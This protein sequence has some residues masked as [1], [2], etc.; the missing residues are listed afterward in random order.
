MALLKSIPEKLE[1]N[2]AEGPSLSLIAPSAPPLLLSHQATSVP[3]KVYYRQGS[4]LVVLGWA[5]LFSS[6][7]QQKHSSFQEFVRL[8][9][10]PDHA[11]W[12]VPGLA[13]GNEDDGRAVATSIRTGSC[14]AISDSSF[15]KDQQ[16]TASWTVQDED[17]FGAL[18]SSLIAPRNPEH[19][20]AYRSELAG[21]LFG[22]AALV[23]FLHCQY[24]DITESAAVTIGCDGLQ[25]LLHA[26][27][28]I[29]FTSTKMA[30]FDLRSNKDNPEKKAQHLGK[31]S[32]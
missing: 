30:Q 2:P 9:V 14:L 12:A 4:Q 10:D 29:D 3:A 16:G 19:Q 6:P 26:A 7:R 11:A 22:V 15:K 21:L 5:P 23:D 24:H 31:L 32:M 27:S 13:V 18:A 20:G 17:S 25:A 1:N 28:N 8:K